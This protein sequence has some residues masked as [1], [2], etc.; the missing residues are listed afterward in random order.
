MLPHYANQNLCELIS[1]NVKPTFLMFP[2]WYLSLDF[3][4]TLFFSGKGSSKK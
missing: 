4:M 1:F 2:F 3:K